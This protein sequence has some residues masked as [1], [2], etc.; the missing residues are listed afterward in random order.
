M[1]SFSLLASS[2]CTL[3]GH[4]IMIATYRPPICSTPEL[5]RLLILLVDV[6]NIR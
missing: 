5:L 1:L 2:L 4:H 6:L 3:V